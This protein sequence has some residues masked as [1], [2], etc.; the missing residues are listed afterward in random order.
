MRF[1]LYLVNIEFGCQSGAEKAEIR[2]FNG[3]RGVYK[4]NL[5]KLNSSGI[6]AKGISG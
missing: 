4:L 1:W 2:A 3:F 6:L 5:I